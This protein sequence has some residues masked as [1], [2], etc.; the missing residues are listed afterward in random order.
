MANFFFLIIF[1]IKLSMSVGH[2]GLK[3][4]GIQAH[5]ARVPQKVVDHYI[6]S[7]QC[8]WAKYF[9]NSWYLANL[10]KDIYLNSSCCRNRSLIF[11]IKNRCNASEIHYMAKPVIQNKEMAKFE[12][13]KFILKKKKMRRIPVLSKEI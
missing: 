9:K 7:K 4:Y 13:K 5:Q 2:V 12:T 8:F 11:K 3:K 1:L 10:A 6:F